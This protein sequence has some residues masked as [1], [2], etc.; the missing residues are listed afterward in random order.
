[1]SENIETL[2]DVSPPQPGQES[3]ETPQ[4]SQVEQDA[5]RELVRQARASGVALTGP[6]GLLKLLTKQVVEAALDEE[7]NEHLGYEPGVPEGRNRGN[8][9]NGRRTKTVITDN[10]GPVQIEVPRDRE[11]TFEPVI[12]KKRQRRLSDLD[13]VVLSLSAKGLTTGEISAHLGEVYGAEVSKDTVT[14][15]TDRVIEEMQA[16]WARPL[17]DVYAAIFID[18]I[19]VKVRDGQVRNRPVYAAIGVDLGGHKD[20]L[21][22]WAGDGD[23]ESAKFWY[24]VLTD[25]KSRGVR[26][27]FFVVC[28]GLKGLPDSVNAVFPAAIVQTCIIHLIR[29]TFRY[30]SRKYWDELAKDL[31]PIYQAP[32]AGAAAEALDALEE[33]WGTRYPAIIRLWRGAWTEFVPFLDYDVEI[34]RVICS[35]NAIESLNARFRRAVRAR[36]HFPNEQSAMK[37][38]YLVVRSLDPKGTGQT[39]WA[40]RWKPALNAFAITFA[41]R[42]PAAENH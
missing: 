42:M 3:E 35:T 6:D 24:A 8:S 14:R 23:G 10:A 5:V 37:T 17:E 40:M 21:G 12:V 9:R 34:R 26:D 32:T 13:Q 29:G 38:L 15:I 16:W 4:L 36:G 41:D 25:L 7:M 18:A 33:K 28:D 31:K 19:M 27:V 30:A 20:I 1:M 2:V 11:G 22:M 39:R